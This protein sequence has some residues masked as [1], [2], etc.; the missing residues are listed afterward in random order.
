MLGEID[1]AGRES[2]NDIIADQFEVP[3]RSG[4]RWRRPSRPWSG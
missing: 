3:R 4:R 1:V 2:A